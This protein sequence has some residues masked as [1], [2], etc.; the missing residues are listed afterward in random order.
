MHYFLFL[1]QFFGYKFVPYI[2]NSIYTNFFI[3]LIDNL[4]LTV[5]LKFFCEVKENISRDE[6]YL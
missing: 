6:T 4:I 5:V 2:F 3:L 1:P